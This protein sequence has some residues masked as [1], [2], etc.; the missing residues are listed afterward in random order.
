MFTIGFIT[1]LLG[2]RA[3]Q[4]AIQLYQLVT[5][6]P[7]PLFLR[8]ASLVDGL[9]P[10]SLSVMVAFRHGRGYAF[11]FLAPIV[12]ADRS[13]PFPPVLLS[14]SSS[15]GNCFLC[16]FASASAC[17]KNSLPPTRVTLHPFFR[18]TFKTFFPAVRILL[19]GSAPASFL[20]WSRCG[21]F[22]V[23]VL[24]FSVQ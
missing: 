19:Y 11:F 13:F 9:A 3:L 7:A 15:R 16:G 14:V 20:S 22:Q 24:P 4:L 5:G 18:R 10:S 23:A 12:V 21:D 1:P 6:P 17:K 2:T 8:K